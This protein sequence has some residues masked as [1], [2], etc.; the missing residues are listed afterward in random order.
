MNYLFKHKNIGILY[1]LILSL[2]MMSCGDDKKISTSTVNDDL[3]K[4][5]KV[6]A[7]DFWQEMC[8]KN[9]KNARKYTTNSSEKSIVKLSKYASQVSVSQFSKVDSCWF[10]A[11]STRAFCSCLFNQN[12]QDKREIVQLVKQDFDWEVEYLLGVTNENVL[13]Y[14]YSLVGIASPPKKLKSNFR[15]SKVDEN[16]FDYVVNDIGGNLALGE[17]DTYSMKESV[18]ESLNLYNSSVGFFEENYQ[19]IASTYFPDVNSLEIT[20]TNFE[21]DNSAEVYQKL[22]ERMVKQYGIPFNAENIKP[23]DYYKYISFRWFYKSFNQQIEI[24]NYKTSIV[25]VFSTI[26]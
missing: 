7:A 18:N 22:V 9:Y 11:D 24:R 20:L 8:E 12:N 5:I 6:V 3:E 25:V 26:V 23:S 10:N 13:M 16:Y 1:L 17:V 4:R 2:N 21:S 15:M 14:D 19:L